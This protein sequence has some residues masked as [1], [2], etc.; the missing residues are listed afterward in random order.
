MTAAPPSA[1]APVTVAASGLGRKRWIALWSLG[2]VLV[3]ARWWLAEPVRVDGVSMEPTLG[4]G[5]HLVLLKPAV[6]RGVRR[7]GSVTFWDSGVTLVKR[8]VGVTGDRVAIRD[9]RLFV[10][11]SVVKE[12]YADP[13]LIDSVYGKPVIVPEESVYLL[14]DNRRES[15]DSRELGTIPLGR[16]EG[17]VVGTWWPPGRIG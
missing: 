17:R 2:V 5:E 13:E 15:L 11:G 10:N 1:S 16:L 3:S 7:G 9:G 14:G 8:V 6:E 4:S 12:E